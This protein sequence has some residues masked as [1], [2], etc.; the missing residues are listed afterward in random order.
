MNVI[1]HCE[2]MEI[3]KSIKYV[4]KVV[5]QENMNKMKAWEKYKFDVMFVGSD[6][7]GTKKWNEFKR[8]FS[9]LGVDIVYFPYTKCTSSTLL[10]EALQ[11]INNIGLAIKK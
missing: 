1:P 9:K 7:K 3:V 10:R 11:K 2:R 4:D 8:Q 5:P 6:W